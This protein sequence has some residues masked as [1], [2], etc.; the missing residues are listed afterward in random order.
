MSSHRLLA[1]A[2]LAALASVTAVGALGVRSRLFSFS[3][4]F[5]FG[6]FAAG[7][8]LLRGLAGRQSVLWAKENR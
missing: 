5:L 2:L 1:R 7:C 4:Y 6:Q 3:F 8:G